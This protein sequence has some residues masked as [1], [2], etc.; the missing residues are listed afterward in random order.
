MT[1]SMTLSHLE[2]YRIPIPQLRMNNVV[3]TT[4]RERATPPTENLSVKTTPEMGEEEAAA[5]PTAIL[6][7]QCKEL[8]TSVLTPAMVSVLWTHDKYACMLVMRG[9]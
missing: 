2:C 7:M 1:F 3:V 4:H 8:K 9:S 5:M 6:L